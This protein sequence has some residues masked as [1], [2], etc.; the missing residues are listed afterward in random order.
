MAL[1]GSGQD[2]PV[3]VLVV[4]DE[5]DLRS[6]VR[7]AL[8]QEG[9]V[10]TTA[11]DLASAR[12]ALDPL[13]ELVVLDLTLPDG[14]GLELCRAL[15]ADAA[16]TPI[17][18]LTAQTDVERRVEALDA[19]ADDFLAK[20]FAIAELRARVRALARRGPL[21][22]GLHFAQGTV[23][24]DFGSR[25]ATREGKPVAVTAREWAILEV[26]AR[27]G[28]RV[29]DRDGLLESTW[30]EATPATSSSLDVLIG[31]LRSKLGADVI[32]TLRGV[33]YALGQER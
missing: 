14:F 15:R 18:V 7:R 4:D 30:G 27:H 6:V 2:D 25:L 22:R 23:A 24:L 12:L 33:G 16:P 13:P 9:H 1:V 29:I 20:P 21:A 26:L 17:L 5:A 3:R 31:R 8:E 11:M 28:G 32:R 10:V 19:G